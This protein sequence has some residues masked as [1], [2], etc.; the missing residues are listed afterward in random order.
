MVKPP[1]RDLDEAVEESIGLFKRAK[2]RAVAPVDPRRPRHVLLAL[3]G[4]SQDALGA[5]IARRFRDRFECAVSVVDAR[6]NVRSNELAAR[7]ALALQTQALPKAAGDNF[8]QILAAVDQS[9]CDL[10]IAPCP[11]GRDLETVGPNS[12]GTV[13]DVL[14]ARSPVPIL[15]VRRPYDPPDPLFRHVQMIL[16]AENEAAP[17]AAAWAAGLI[18]AGGVLRLRLVLERE[19]YQNFQALLESIAPGVDVS[20]TSLS[21]ALAQTYMRLHRSLQKTAQDHGFEYKLRLQVEGQ[22]GPLAGKQERAHPLIVLALERRDHASLG[23]VQTRIRHTPC[24]VLVVCR[25]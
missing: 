25:D 2:V 22:S 14:L 6:E 3:D 1:L 17:E 21:Q 10:L 15:V 4:S 20:A 23:S 8:A 13:I 16:T 5:A 11:Y 24:P 19:M 12:A 18:A 7:T 9:Q